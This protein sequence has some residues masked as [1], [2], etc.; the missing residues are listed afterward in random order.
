MN[1]VLCIINTHIISWDP[2]ESIYIEVSFGNY[3]YI[4]M[5]IYIHIIYI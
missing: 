4:C 5:I 3:I 1:Q 2:T